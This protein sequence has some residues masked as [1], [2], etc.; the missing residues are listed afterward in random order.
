M[1]KNMTIPELKQQGYKDLTY[2]EALKLHGKTI[3]VYGFR[4]LDWLKQE[5]DEVRKVFVDEDKVYLMK[6]R[7]TKKAFLL[8]NPIYF[9]LEDCIYKLIY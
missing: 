6:P 8:A 7:A 1:G 9:A 5:V 3:Q 2:Q 4:Q